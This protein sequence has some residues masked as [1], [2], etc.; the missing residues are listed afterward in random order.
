[1]IG[2]LESVFLVPLTLGL[3]W[4]RGNK[5]GALS[6]MLVGLVSFIAFYRV[7]GT[8]MYNLHPVVYSITLSLITYIIVSMITRKPSEE[9]IKKFF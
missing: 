4:S 9:V 7:F 8:N 1:A 2:G 5:Y 6:S 3:F